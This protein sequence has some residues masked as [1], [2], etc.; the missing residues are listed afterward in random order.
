MTAE[1][2]NSPLIKEADWNYALWWKRISKD[3]IQARYVSPFAVILHQE[4]TY[5][6][7]GKGT[8]IGHFCLIDGSQGLEIGENCSISSGVQIYTHSTHK[9]AAY[10]MPKMVAPTKIGN[11]VFIGPNSVVSLGC[12]IGDR[13]IIA[14]VSFIAPFSDIQ[15]QMKVEG[16]V[17]VTRWSKTRDE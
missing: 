14:P 3:N 12:T 13:V 11:N 16:H 7:I 8:W 10:D 2:P 6:K 4:G 1:L 5:P 9:K 17:H 15:P